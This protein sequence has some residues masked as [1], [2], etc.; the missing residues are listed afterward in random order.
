MSKFKTSRELA[1][2]MG[3]SQSHVRR[4]LSKGSIKGVKRGRDWLITGGTK[5]L[6]A[7]RYAE[8]FELSPSHIRLL[9]REGI[10][11][12]EKIG[13]DWVIYDPEQEPYKRHRRRKSEK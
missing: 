8:E 10:I 5:F 4:L 7:K 13:R 6:T 2:A 9:L 12:G 3:K 11:K 1:Q